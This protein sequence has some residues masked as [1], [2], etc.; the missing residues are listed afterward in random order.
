MNTNIQTLRLDFNKITDVGAVYISGLV[1][2]C[3]G[4][5]HLSMSYNY[6]G[7]QGAMAIAGVLY[8]S[9]VEL[10]LQSNSLNDE[11]AIA[12]AKSIKDFP[13]KFQLCLWNVNITTE[14][15]QKVLVYRQTAIIR[16]EILSHAWKM[17]DIQRPEAVERAIYNKKIPSCTCKEFDL[18]LNALNL[19]RSILSGWPQHSS[20]LCSVNL[21]YC[22]I[23]HDEVAFLA[24]SL[25]CC[26]NLKILNLSHNSID[27]RG[28]KAIAFALKD[29]TLESLNLRN[30]KIGGDGSLAL[31]KALRSGSEV[32][33]LELG[34][35]GMWFQ[36]ELNRNCQTMIGHKWC[37][38]L[39]ELDLG[40]N[41]IRDKG[42]VALAYG[43][44]KCIRLQ[45]LTLSNNNIYDDSARTL[46]H[47]LNSSYTLKTLNLDDNE[48]CGTYS[49][50]C[51]INLQILSLKHCLFYGGHQMIYELKCCNGLQSLNLSNNK[52][53]YQGVLALAEALKT[54]SN[55][56]ELIYCNNSHCF[57]HNLFDGLKCYKLCVLKM[58]SNNMQHTEIIALLQGLKRCTHLQV[59]ELDYNRF[60]EP[61][62]RALVNLLQSFTN[63]QTLGLSGTRID[64]NCAKVLVNGLKTCITLQ[65]LNICKNP[66]HN[67]RP[68]T[69]VLHNCTILTD[70]GSA[71]KLNRKKIESK[72]A[73]SE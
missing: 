30:N 22:E 46:I 52:I 8:H 43:L 32:I 65:S 64:D 60:N 73:K 69:G 39:Q 18:S 3:A 50:Q 42:A 61:A 71:C 31:S 63:I 37:T 5:L 67:V 58:K 62:V 28:I 21:S 51:C 27:V 35:T 44:K 29:C 49:L 26:N 56:Q 59:L 36:Y 38:S 48:L 55:L 2:E 7:D 53:S 12:V 68:L 16:N 33:P 66:I 34:F 6:I 23:G 24:H 41:N 14:G 25:S 45:S 10:D 17:V 70:Q 72:T 4:L 47:A 54:W 20:S 11:G 40:N 19:S 1:R 9:L 13:R 15:I 57:P